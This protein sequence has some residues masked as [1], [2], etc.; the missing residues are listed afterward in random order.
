VENENEIGG[1]FSR[2][3]C[4]GTHTDT[5]GSIGNFKIIKEESIS[6]GVRRIT[7]MTGE[8][9]NKFFEQR[10]GIVDELSTMLKVPSEQLVGRVQKLLDDNKKLSKELK[11]ARKKGAVDIMA[12]AKALL[13]KAE[14]L[15]P[16]S[17][18]TGRLSAGSAEE[19]RGAIDMLRKKAKSA[20]IVLGMADE[21]KVT[22]LA[23]VTDDLVK[24]GL[25]AGELV[26]AIAPI[27]GGGGGGGPKMAQAGGKNP[28]KIEEALT[29]AAE[30]IK[31][32]LAD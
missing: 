10:S 28:D 20:A 31:E 1:A 14:L 9:L 16:T 12:E 25:K 26:K 21:G 11:S 8:G 15:G 6:A 5:T 4:G 27:V 19:G 29:K 18:I 24:K 2:E 13:S 23:G 7:A 3:F 32:K 17:I 22:L 30:I